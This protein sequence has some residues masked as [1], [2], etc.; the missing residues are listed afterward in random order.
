MVAVEYQFDKS[1]YP[2]QINKSTI[3]T[4]L[5]FVSNGFTMSDKI[6]K[7]TTIP[8]IYYAV[9]KVRP[10]N[11]D[12]LDE[13]YQETNSVR[14]EISPRNRLSK[15]IRKNVSAGVNGH[16]LFVGS[17]GAGKST[18]LNHLQKDMEQEIA[19]INYS[20]FKEL[21]PQNISYIELF[22]VTMEKLFNYASDKGT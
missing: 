13:F 7:A 1:L 22:I 3:S 6:R 20:V 2:L 18:E 17:K 15:I 5:T 8:E 4:L 21:D 9:G 11:V 16:F 19:V 10:L 14:S 12:E